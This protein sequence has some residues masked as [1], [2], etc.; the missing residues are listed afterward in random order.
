[1][2]R[3]RFS[4][5]K[6]NPTGSD[7]PDIDDS[8][9][10]TIVSSLED[11]AVFTTTMDGTV[12][13]WNTGAEKILG[14]TREEILGKNASL[15]F[16]PED[17]KSGVP[18]KELLSAVRKKRARDERW[19]LRKDGT[20]FWASGLVFPLKDKKRKIIGLTK[21]MRDLT[22]RKK[23]EE[24]REKLFLLEQEAL[25]KTERERQHLFTLFQQAPAMICILR[26]SRSIVE[27]ANPKFLEL[28][29]GANVMGQPMRK[30]WPELKGQGFFEIISKVYATGSLVYRSE[31]PARLNRNG[32]GKLTESFF[33]FV[34]APYRDADGSVKG[35]ML[36]GFDVTEQVRSKQRLQI[37]EERLLLAQKSG[38]IGTFE[39]NAKTKQVLW[40]PQLAQLYGADNDQFETDQESW[41]KRVHPEDRKRVEKE[42]NHALKS[43]ED[44]NTEFRVVWPDNS[45]HYLAAR[46]QVFFDK[47]GRPER[48]VGVNID[49]T[50][51][52]N[53]ENNLLFLTEASKTLSSSLDYETTLSTVARLA[54]PEIADWCVVDLLDTE[55]NIKQ[56][57]VAHKDPK[58]VKW[59][60][61][62][63]KLNPPDMNAKTGLANVLRTGKSELYPLITDAILVA[64]AKNE[65]HLKLIRSLGFTSAMVVPLFSQGRP[66]GAITFVT[67]ETRRRYNAADLAMA[68]ELAGRASLAIENARLYK[69][70]QEAIALRDDFISVA[71]HELKTPITSVKIFTQVLQNYCDHIGDTKAK[72]YLSKM[73]KQLNKLTEL[74]YN[75]L[76]ISKIQAG[77]IEFSKKRFDFDAAVAE[78]VSI[79]QESAPKHIIEIK[80]K[81]GKMVYGDEDR[82]GQ[83]LSNLISNAVKYSPGAKKV[84][85]HLSSTSTHVVVCVEDFGIGMD[86]QHLHR[87]FERFYR[88][89]EP[90]DKTF[91]GLGIGLYISSEI[92][93]RHDGDFWVDSEPGK[94]SRFFFSIPIALPRK[95]G[96][97]S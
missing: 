45:I 21:V 51:R 24:Q 22:E 4:K 2:A 61:E 50:E 83:V 26:G 48:M 85:V 96:K 80:G 28:W 79:M 10:R 17:R 37:S 56:V 35:V 6:S 8:F 47:K 71:S 11:Y 89:S 64:T 16:T 86:E 30:A 70:S 91:P 15:F 3:I 7:T 92:I 81:T 23:L 13:S 46:A 49:I 14:Y 55:R 32:N 27:L 42:F 66:I 18:I 43:G 19:H 38:K 40:T 75:L 67:T 68:E 63:R 52:K 65:Q 31:F 57:A 69:G 82:I 54:V 94:G 76:D 44:F 93:K 97:K 25:A 60:K 74:I 95:K 62:Y 20:R 33:N 77:R 34:F 39:W 29:G 90:T 72:N 73:D 88:V 78:I 5:T 59:A 12:T 84:Q 87:I 1:M 36:F 41:S 58:K 9:F 53:I